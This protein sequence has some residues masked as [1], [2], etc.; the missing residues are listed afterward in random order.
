MKRM[1][2]ITASAILIAVLAFVPLV[3]RAQ[4]PFGGKV[5]A[6]LPCN[7]GSLLYVA[8]SKG[9]L[10]FMWLTGNLRY[11]SFTPPHVGQEML[12]VAA[13]VAM[14]CVLGVP[15]FAV[16][17]GAGLPIIYHGSSGLAN[18]ASVAI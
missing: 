11:L 10:P 17:L 6:Q 8:T 3:A 13:T 16:I 18:S 2:I 5:V 15:P 9:P 1:K 12:G 14:P 7:T 4:V